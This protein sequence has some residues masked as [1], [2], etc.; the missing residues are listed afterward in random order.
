MK[1]CRAKSVIVVAYARFVTKMTSYYTFTY[2]FR[3]RT[4]YL[5]CHH[6]LEMFLGASDDAACCCKR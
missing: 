5:K 1:S 3:T 2:T 4:K 6:G